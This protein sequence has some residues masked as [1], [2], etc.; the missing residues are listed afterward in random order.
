M[1]T[2]KPKKLTAEENLK[3]ATG[4]TPVVYSYIRFSHPR[5]KLGDSKRRQLEATR[6]WAA[7]KGYPLDESLIMQDEGLSG[8]HGEHKL[9]GKLGKFLRLVEDGKVPRGSWLVLESLDRLSREA[10]S[11]ALVDFLQLLN[12]GVNIVT[13]AD[14]AREYTRESVALNPNDLM[15]SLGIMWRAYEESATK[16]Y[17]ARGNWSSMLTRARSKEIISERCPGWLKI[18]GRKKVGTKKV[19]G[20]WKK[21]PERVKLVQRIYRLR[22][23][24]HGFTSIAQMLNSEK[25]LIP[26]WNKARHG[27]ADSTIKHLLTDRAVLGYFVPDRVPPGESA[28]PV[29]GYYPRIITEKTFDKV[30]GIIRSFGRTGERKG[31]KNRDEVSNLFPGLLRCGHCGGPMHLSRNTKVENGKKYTYQFL[32]CDA[33]RRGYKCEETGTFRYDLLEHAILISLADDMVVSDLR[34]GAADRSKIEELDAE[35]SGIL[36]SI[37]GLKVK[38]AA[39]QARFEDCADSPALLRRASESLDKIES[40]LAALTARYRVLQTQHAEEVAVQ[41]AHDAAGKHMRLLVEEMHATKEKSEKNSLRQRLSA[42][43]ALLVERIVLVPRKQR[44]SSEYPRYAVLQMRA[45]HDYLLHEVAEL[46]RIK[47]LLF[48]RYQ[49]DE[50]KRL[51]APR[52]KGLRSH[53]KRTFFSK[54]L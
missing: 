40:E 42:R 31:G 33:A 35:R 37:E 4:A 12:A 46:G 9:K 1:S 52:L 30:Q 15:I 28:E 50:T 7:K 48:E 49:G 45:G 23:A 2:R 36:Q 38:R 13:L 26:T 43:I 16:Q 5:Q 51:P 29:G 17:R 10:V 41:E 3:P 44:G 22:L 25:P 32:A 20:R 11:V 8:F 18:T 54:K 47:P 53:P 24:G 6:A 34:A 39:F 19:G 21:I 27:W 14:G